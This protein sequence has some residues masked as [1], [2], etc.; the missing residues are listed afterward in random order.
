MKPFFRCPGIAFYLIAYA[1][2]GP[3]AMS[4]NWAHAAAPSNGP[5]EIALRALDQYESGAELPPVFYRVR[6]VQYR[7][8]A[9]TQPVM[10]Q[11]T[12]R[13]QVV[14]DG[15]TQDFRSERTAIDENGI[16]HPE[17]RRSMR[18]LIKDGRLYDYSLNL[19]GT[20]DTPVLISNP[21]ASPQAIAIRGAFALEGYPDGYQSG[22]VSDW[23]RAS[24]D[25]F[26]QS[27]GADG[28]ERL[29][30]TGTTRHG[31]V[32]LTLAPD[33]RYAMVGL[34]I[35]RGSGDLLGSDS[36]TP[37]GS[38]PTP[39][40]M[41][42]SLG[43]LEGVE[44][45]LVDRWAIPTAGAWSDVARRR[46]GS[47]VGYVQACTTPELI[48]GALPKTAHAALELNLPD[49][50][51]IHDDS[52]R[53]IQYV[54]RNGRVTPRVDLRVVRQMDRM[55]GRTTSGTRPTSRPSSAVAKDPR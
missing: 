8:R 18:L 3:L 25:L 26:S 37:A 36:L 21:P 46:N 54:W 35:E 31:T 6:S 28:A 14:R 12:E 39:Q 20:I 40:D 4:W 19:D 42:S 13:M 52:A 11:E 49:G 10:I 38:D 33:R 50:T 24:P 16:S 9:V 2:F 47:T 44:H 1:G 15:A 23:L 41:I 7:S 55:L 5:R 30:I 34:R 48:V 45:R 51:A 32:K 29:V 43:N 27:A 53:Q 17:Y 22:R